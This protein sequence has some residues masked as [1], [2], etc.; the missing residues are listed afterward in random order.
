MPPPNLS[1][2]SREVMGHL[3]YLSGMMNSTSIVG[4]FSEKVLK[5]F[6]HESQLCTYVSCSL[7]ELRDI[8]WNIMGTIGFL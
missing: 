6:Q 7:S 5:I 3:L 2:R 4:R 8:L 1:Y